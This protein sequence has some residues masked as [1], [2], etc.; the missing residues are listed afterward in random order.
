MKKNYFNVKNIIITILVILLSLTLFNPGGF[1]PMRTNYITKLDSVP[2]EVIDTLYFGV[3]TQIDNPNL[4]NGLGMGFLYQTKQDKI[5]KLGIG[6]NN[7]ITDGTSGTFTPYVDAGV[8]W[9][10]KL[11]K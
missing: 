7:R 3:N 1:L 2:Y 4:V 8:Y 11:R 5:F 9:K 6:V 10:V